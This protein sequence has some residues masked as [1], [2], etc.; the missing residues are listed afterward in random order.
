MENK[1]PSLWHQH[2]DEVLNKLPLT[3]NSAKLIGS[4]YAKMS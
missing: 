1:Y 4:R 3:T 2:R